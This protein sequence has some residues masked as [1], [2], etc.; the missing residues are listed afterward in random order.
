[1]RAARRCPGQPRCSPPPF[2]P[3]LCRP[4]PA[5]P[6]EAEKPHA[7]WDHDDGPCLRTASRTERCGLPGLPTA[8][9]RPPR[10]EVGRRPPPHRERDE[11]QPAG[12]SSQKIRCHL[13]P[14]G[15]GPGVSLAGGGPIDE[16]HDRCD[17]LLAVEQSAVVV[18]R[19]LDLEDWAASC[20][21]T[22]RRSWPTTTERCPTSATTTTPAR[23]SRRTPRGCWRRPRAHAPGRAWP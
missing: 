8:G 15:D 14:P 17:Q 3:C 9:V 11:Q 10:H 19:T 7:E 5:L 4:V 2:P 23:R 1:M 22:W 21:P 20:T 16:F 6:R 18:V 12:R 13:I